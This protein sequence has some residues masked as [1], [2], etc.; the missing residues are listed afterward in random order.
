MAQACDQRQHQGAV[1][2]RFSPHPGMAGQREGPQASTRAPAHSQNAQDEAERLG[3]Q[4]HT[5]QRSRI[6]VNPRIG[7]P[8]SPEVLGRACAARCQGGPGLG[9]VPGSQVACLASPCGTYHHGSHVCPGNTPEVPIKYAS[10]V[11]HRRSRDA[12]LGPTKQGTV[13]LGYMGPDRNPP[14]PTAKVPGGRRE[15]LFP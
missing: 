3:I 1:D 14:S 8:A 6:R 10:V 2:R 7:L 11:H 5:D 12:G 4:V 9:R 15:A 13:L